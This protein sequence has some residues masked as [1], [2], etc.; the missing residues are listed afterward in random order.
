MATEYTS[1][2]LFES[3][4]SDS[5]D[6]DVAPIQVPKTV[7]LV[8]KKAPRSFVHSERRL[9]ER[10]RRDPYDKENFSRK[11]QSRSNIKETPTRPKSSE[12]VRSR[13]DGGQDSS[14]VLSALGELTSTLNKVVK[15]LEKT[16]CRIQSMEDKMDSTLSSSASDTRRKS[17]RKVPVI[18]RVSSAL[19]C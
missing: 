13:S 15:R 3:S 7:P 2:E 8:S 4:S 6:E 16:E 19:N 5:E 9:G 12:L 18:V 14:A 11:E 17:I 10:L 1:E